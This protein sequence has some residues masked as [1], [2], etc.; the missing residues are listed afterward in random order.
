MQDGSA[1]TTGEEMEQL[2]SYMSRLNLTTKN[3]TA[4]GI[5]HFCNLHSYMS[6]AMLKKWGICVL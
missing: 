4:A 5:P 3:M 1:A 2:F 6:N